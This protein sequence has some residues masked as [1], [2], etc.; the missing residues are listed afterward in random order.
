MRHDE[1]SLRRAI[2]ELSSA[3]T[4]KFKT[5][6]ELVS[7]SESQ[8]EVL[9]PVFDAIAEHLE[10]GNKII[11]WTAFQ[12][13]ANLAAADHDDRIEGTLDRYLAPIQGPV[14][15]TAGHAIR[16]A[17]R[18]AATHKQLTAKVV[19]AILGVEAATYATKECRNIAIGH[20]ISVLGS[21][22]SEVKRSAEVTAFVKRQTVNPRPATRKKAEHFLKKEAQTQVG[23][24]VTA[25][26][27]RAA[28]R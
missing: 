25:R 14:M 10:A 17:A 23:G 26:R 22:D 1:S 4:E 15:I 8:P 12:I 21:M 2:A 9:Y 24:S 19:R 27:P 13:I 3:G 28:P 5:A 11:Q 7:L 20:A 18:I 16:G 6:K